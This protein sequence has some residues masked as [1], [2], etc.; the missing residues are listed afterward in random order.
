M[1]PLNKFL[2]MAVM[3]EV[4]S[5]AQL[6][7]DRGD[8][9]NA[10]DSNG[11]TLLMLLA[12]KNKTAMCQFL[13]EA[14]ADPSLLDPS[15]RTAYAIA[16]SAGAQQVAD[17]LKPITSAPAISEILVTEQTPMTN[18]GTALSQDE[19]NNT[20]SPV[21][22]SSMNETVCTPALLSV[23]PVTID[24]DECSF[25]LSDWVAEEE[26]PPPE[27]DFSIVADASAIQIAISDYKPIDSSI[28]WDDVEA[29]LPDQSAPFSRK[30][31]L[32]TRGR[33]RLA[34]IRAIRE[35]SVPEMEIESLSVDEDGNYNQEF[36][37]LLT[38]VIN[39]LGAEVDERFEYITWDE[40]FSVHI[41]KEEAADEEEVI[42]T[43]IRFIDSVTSRRAEPLRIYLRDIQ[44]VKLI[45][46]EEEVIFSQRMEEQHRRA[47]D[48]LAQWPRGLNLLL[49]AGR[50]VQK[51]QRAISSIS[52]GPVE[53]QPN[54]DDPSTE[55]IIFSTQDPTSDD[56]EDEVDEPTSSPDNS[57]SVFLGTLLHLTSLVEKSPSENLNKEIR[58]QID[59]LRLNSIFLFDLLSSALQDQ[60]E[61]AFEFSAAM[62]CYM[63]ARERMAT[64]NLKLVFHIAKKF[65][66]SGL[67]LEDLTQEGNIGLLKAVERFD[68]RRGYKFSTYA[69]WWIR[70]QIGRAIADSARTIR[71]P[72]HMHEKLQRLHKETLAF[73]EETRRPPEPEEI[74]ARLGISIRNWETLQRVPS[75]PMSINDFFN[76]D[77]IDPIAGDNIVSPDP[78]D[79]YAEL[80]LCETVNNV[81]STLKPKEEKVLR[82]RFG[83]GITNALTLEEA[84]AT[85]GL[86]RERIRQIE[87][88]ALRRLSTAEKF[89]QLSIASFGYVPTGNSASAK[90]VDHD[91]TMIVV[92]QTIDDGTDIESHNAA[93]AMIDREQ[94]PH[95]VQSKA[96]NRLLL[97]LEDAGIR[98]VDERTATSGKVWVEI[99]EMN[100][101]RDRK[102]IRKMLDIGFS[103]IPGRGYW[104]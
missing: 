2:K 32:E 101:T 72:V 59:L 47:L 26:L 54:L 73:E 57:T 90:P 95:V 91:E 12:A 77:L 62:K 17:V 40:N 79:S 29:F 23:I 20:E 15:G 70:Q 97:Q 51:Q 43:A 100:D 89:N 28:D 46:G 86:T 8:D 78:F 18:I 64:A 81:I 85:Y 41:S 30:E 80:Q 21:E 19:R 11:L 53:K 38:L 63:D 99:A 39:D 102:F 16:I 24:Y 69:T 92:K 52:L 45:T 42:D 88:K 76:D 93:A 74:V 66:Y 98:V 7:I 10:R 49:D 56:S 71:I 34:L 48:A 4:K 44:K 87:A 58:K 50:L 96:L 67:S 22:A 37:E 27:P 68:W 104:K 103:F 36:K 3:G 35:G 55:T 1:R 25:E 33:L 5:A 31:N 83:I 60:G 61:A 6:H 9:L 94:N 75:E 84:G 82:M 14:G 65:M 13:L